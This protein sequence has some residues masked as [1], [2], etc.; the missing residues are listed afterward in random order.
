MRVLLFT[1][2][3]P[4]QPLVKKVVS[5]LSPALISA[6]K[7][8]ALLLPSS[9]QRALLAGYTRER[10]L[11]S[12][13]GFLS[14]MLKQRGHTV[15]LA[16][17]LVDSSAWPSDIHSYDFVGVHTTTPCYQD[18]LDVLDRLKK[19]GFKG[20]IAFGGPHTTLYPDTIPPAVDYVVQGEAEYLICDLVEGVYPSNSLLVA[21]RILDLDALPQPDYSLFFDRAR[22]YQ[23]NVPFFAGNRVF[24]MTTSR[25]C[26]WRCAFCSVK[27]VWGR[28]WTKHSPERIVND[29]QF[30]QENYQIDGVYFREDLFTADKKRVLKFCE[31]M[32][33]RKR[34]IS[35]AVETR[36][37][38][39]RDATLVEAMADA[40][41]RGFYIGAESG[42]QRMLDI[43][44]KDSLVEDTT[45]ALAVAKHYG[46]KTAMSIIVGNPEETLADRHA[47]YRMVKQCKP[48]ILQCSVFN[49]VHTGLG[50]LRY[51]RYDMNRRQLIPVHF[52]NSSRRGQDDRRVVAAI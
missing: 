11:P 43:Y 36:A 20:K 7:E 25:S 12:G 44:A 51:E 52:G 26:P 6:L 38:D 16:D 32:K 49:G 42:S 2:G 46:I 39:A 29:I 31:L 40:G 22:S 45:T 5:T 37:S 1:I 9:M 3:F 50:S 17:R 48:E 34:K 28:L 18:G 15:H 19:E 8:G 41:C 4:D 33:N 47:T 24:N 10:R 23:L 30:L 35:W 27:A 13:L 14:A 21:P